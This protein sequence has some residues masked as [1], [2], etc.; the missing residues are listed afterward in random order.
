M[1]FTFPESWQSQVGDAWRHTS[2]DRLRDFLKLEYTTRKVY[3]ATEHVFN[4]MTLTPP[5][6]VRV[7][8]LGQDPYHGAGQAHGLAFSVQS[9][10]KPPPSLANIFKELK[11]DIGATGAPGVGDLS[12]WG[13]KGVLLLNAILTVR[14]SEPLSHK[15]KGWEPFTDAVLQAVN[16]G[17]PAVFVLWGSHAQKKLPLIDT[18]RHAVIQSAH[19]SPL[20]AHNGFF[21]SRPFS[22]ANEALRRMGRGEIDWK[23]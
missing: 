9:G 11:A 16:K 12:A 21:G 8:I 5:P 3:P 19:P 20:S 18:S 23:L 2:L 1:D 13:R 14:D 17:P 4:A 15:G 7:V 6:D 22:R 10:V